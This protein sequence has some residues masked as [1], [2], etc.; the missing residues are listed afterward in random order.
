M[1]KVIQTQ[2][3]PAP[4]GPYSQAMQFNDFL[5]C[6]G[7]ISIDPKTNEVFL[8]DIQVQTQMVMSN[9]QAVL[10]EAGMNFSN[11]IK[12]TIYLTNMADFPKVNEIYAKSFK[13]NFPARSTVAVSGLPKGVNVEIEVLAHR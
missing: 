7:Q 6:S 1:K 9:I 8:G 13:E 10:A 5:F 4:V 2:Q 3:A 12:T 11:V